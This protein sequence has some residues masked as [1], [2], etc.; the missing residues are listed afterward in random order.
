MDG[1]MGTGL[2]AGHAMPTFQW[3][4]VFRFALSIRMQKIAGADTNA[5]AA[6]RAATLID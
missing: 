1:F 4:T 6:R 5:R 3:V 2:D